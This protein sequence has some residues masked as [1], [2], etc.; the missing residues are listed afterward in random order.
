MKMPI[1][2]L[3]L[4][5]P[6]ILVLLAILW[7]AR[8][9]SPLQTTQTKSLG[10]FRCP[11]DYESAEEYIQGIGKWASEEIK[12]T[13][14]ITDRTAIANAQQKTLDDT[15]RQLNRLTQMRYR[16]LIDDE[17]FLSE[18]TKL[19]EQLAILRQNA[20]QTENRADKWLELTEKTFNFASKAEE[21][22]L[23]G[24]I[25]TKKEIFLDMG[26]NCTLKDKKLSIDTMK[27]LIP[28]VN[29]KKAI[30]AAISEWELKKTNGLNTISSFDKINLMMR[31][32]PD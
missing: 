14:E 1:S 32:R 20:R 5:V 18:K 4:F 3:K 26:W 17:G 29:K 8:T 2:K 12:R 13:P 9:S 31:G 11:N 22:F 19:K 30:E 25:Q 6:I 23:N 7:I 28:I 24:D 27:W 16:D 21:R 15:Q 10:G